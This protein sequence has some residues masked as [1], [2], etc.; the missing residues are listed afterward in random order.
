MSI[1]KKTPSRSESVEDLTDAQLQC[2]SFRH[3][4]Q[5][6]VTDRVTRR[7]TEVIEFTRISVCRTCGTQIELVIDVATFRT[8]KSTYSYKDGYQVVGGVKMRDAR[9]EF[10]GRLGSRS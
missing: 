7:G 8:K 3:I 2:R 1:K 4:N 5:R 9:Q 6:H 10:I